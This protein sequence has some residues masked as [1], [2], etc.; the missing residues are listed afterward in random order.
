MAF[1]TY[2]IGVVVEDIVVDLGFVGIRFCEEFVGFAKFHK[3]LDD[4]S[5]PLSNQ[6]NFFVFSP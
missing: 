1:K 3:Y 5:I 6:L 4:G 2:D